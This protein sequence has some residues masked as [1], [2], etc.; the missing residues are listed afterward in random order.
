MTI[1]I[2]KFVQ[3]ANL[4]NCVNFLW[5]LLQLEFFVEGTVLKT[6]SFRHWL[7]SAKI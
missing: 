3:S 1:R 6:G 4:K 5:L 2:L 7:F